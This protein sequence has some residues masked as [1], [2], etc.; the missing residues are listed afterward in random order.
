MHGN[1]LRSLSV[2]YLPGNVPIQ[3]GAAM[4]SLSQIV[5]PLAES[6][7][8]V[9]KGIKLD[10]AMVW[11]VMTEG[12]FCQKVFPIGEVPY[13]PGVSYELVSA[14]TLSELL[15][16]IRVKADAIEVKINRRTELER[17]EDDEQVCWELV[18]QGQGSCED[19]WQ[20]AVG[21]G[22]TDLLAAAALLMEVAK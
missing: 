15:D 3:L 14:P 6:R 10:T 5:L 20:Q 21:K 22:S 19:D 8:L 2:G 4:T 7:L 16:A 11:F 12:S 13:D 1:T 9:E 17:H 18:G